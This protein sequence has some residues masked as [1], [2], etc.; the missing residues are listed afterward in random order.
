MSTRGLTF[1]DEIQRAIEPVDRVI[2]VVGPNAVR[3]D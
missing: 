2:A 1:L 3:S